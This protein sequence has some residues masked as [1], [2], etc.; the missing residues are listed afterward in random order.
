MIWGK[1]EGIIFVTDTGN[2]YA[3][4]AFVLSDANSYTYPSRT[5]LGDSR[6]SRT[7][8]GITLISVAKFET[9]RAARL[10]GDFEST[11]RGLCNGEDD[12]AK[13]LEG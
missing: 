6:D 4:Y 12:G 1:G 2:I 7:I 9:I 8:S 13:Q 3:L 5:Y 10:P 11:S